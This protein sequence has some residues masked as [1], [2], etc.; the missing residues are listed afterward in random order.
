MTKKIAVM[1]SGSGSN[2]EAIVKFFENTDV[3]ITCISNNKDAYILKRAE[4][5]GVEYLYLPYE[6][7]AKYFIENK[8]DLGVLAGYMRILNKETLKECKFLNIHPSLLPAFKGKNAI[9]RA[10]NYGVKVSGV[11]V[12]HVDETLDKGKI[13]AQFPVIIDE[14]MNLSDFENEIHALEHKLYPSV[15]KAVLEDKLF[16]FDM[17]LKSNHSH[18]G[19]C[20]GCGGCKK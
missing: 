3:K 17:L 19:G 4:K 5:L 18:Q 14:T 16:S 9:E 2:F 11:T 20:G 8:F 12:H 15:I 10:F 1:G 6:E 13:I 7:N